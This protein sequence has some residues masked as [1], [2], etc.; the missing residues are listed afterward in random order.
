[1]AGL[2]DYF[3]DWYYAE[4]GREGAR[5]LQGFRALNEQ[6]ARERGLEMLVELR[7]LMAGAAELDWGIQAQTRPLAEAAIADLSERYES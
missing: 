3:R 5:K 7:A 6:H 1:M 4:G 2:G